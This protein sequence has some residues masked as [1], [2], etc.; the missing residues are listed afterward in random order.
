MRWEHFESVPLGRRKPNVN[1]LYGYENIHIF[2]A[3]RL[4]NAT[5]YIRYNVWKYL[6]A[7]RI[8]KNVGQKGITGVWGRSPQ[9]KIGYMVKK[10]W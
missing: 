9:R 10:K 6:F 5:L 2:V 4:V 3:V 1:I 7:A 8:V